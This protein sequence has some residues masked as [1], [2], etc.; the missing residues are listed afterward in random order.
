MMSDDKK[1]GGGKKKF[2]NFTHAQD[3]VKTSLH[4][5]KYV[6][7][8]VFKNRC[9]D[10]QNLK[11]EAARGHLTNLCMLFG[12]W[13]LHQDSV[14]CY[15]CGYFTKLPD[16]Q[17]FSS[18]ILDAIK[19]LNARIRPYAISLIE[20]LEITD[21]SLLSAIGNSY[22]DIYEKHLELAK[23]SRMNTTKAGDAIPDGYIENIMP[24]L[25]A[26]M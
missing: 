19:I 8:W 11:C 25:K 23:G 18:L 6:S 16:G 24:I 9:M 1:A 2:L 17:K 22:G 5:L 26:K 13:Q 12:L 20:S 21:N 7:F 3:T 14:A 4:H 15:E 10:E